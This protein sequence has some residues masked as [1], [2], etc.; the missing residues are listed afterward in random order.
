MVRVLQLASL[1]V[2]SAVAFA[3][4]PRSMARRPATAL[5]AKI[6]DDA[7]PEISAEDRERNQQIASALTAVAALAF[8][9]NLAETLINAQTKGA[10]FPG[11]YKEWNYTGNNDAICAKEKEQG[12]PTSTVCSDFNQR[13]GKKP[14]STSKSIGNLNSDVRGKT[15]TRTEIFPP[16]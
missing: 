16:K 9:G 13:G 3:P 8:F 7:K 4:A 2:G 12:L 6:D 1:L 14:Q 5:W 11:L 15:S 10:A